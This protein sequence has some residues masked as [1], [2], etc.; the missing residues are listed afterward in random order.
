MM[1]SGMSIKMAYKKEG[2]N[3]DD[4]DWQE[5][6]M[7]A[8]SIAKT[9]LIRPKHNMSGRA[10][11]VGPKDLLRAMGYNELGRQLTPAVWKPGDKDDDSP[12]WVKAD[13]KQA[14]LCHYAIPY[15]TATENAVTPYIGCEKYE[16]LG[17][18]VRFFHPFVFIAEEKTWYRLTGGTPSEETG[19]LTVKHFAHVLRMTYEA[20]T[21]VCN[22]GWVR[23]YP[24]AAHDK[25]GQLYYSGLEE[26]APSYTAYYKAG[27][28]HNDIVS[29]DCRKMEFGP[30]QLERARKREIREKAI[31]I[32][33]EKARAQEKKNLMKELSS[34]MRDED[35]E[36]QRKLRRE[37]LARQHEEMEIAVAK[38][39]QM[40]AMRMSQ[41][42]MFEKLRMEQED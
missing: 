36:F 26:H 41:S 1:K 12:G 24:M 16:D 31:K 3:S 21:I 29:F 27:K 33:S 5:I 22:N 4:I 10:V 11:P 7:D 13:G 14:P 23:K 20:N 34:H 39:D 32:A 42:A 2:V 37:Q 35:D 8:E 40:E 18:L 15:V 38:K 30:E 19:V 28:S 9:M 25:L 17:P 6:G